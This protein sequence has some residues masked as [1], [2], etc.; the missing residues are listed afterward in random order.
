MVYVPV[1]MFSRRN[2][3][4]AFVLTVKQKQADKGWDKNNCVA[5]IYTGILETKSWHVFIES[6]RFSFLSIPLC[7]QNPAQANRPGPNMSAHL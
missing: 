7:E 3:P 2:E 6:L 4:S 5:L 1:V